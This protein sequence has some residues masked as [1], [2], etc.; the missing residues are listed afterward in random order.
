MSLDAF[1]AARKV[2]GALDLRHHIVHLELIDPADIPRFKEL[3]VVANFQGLWAYPDEYITKLTEPIL[4][5]ER[6]GRLYPIGSV[7]RSGA[8][9]AGGSDWSVSSLNPLEAIQVAV[10]RRSIDGGEGPAWL[11]NELID[12]RTALEAYTVNGAYLSHRET[13]TG[14]IE[15]EKSADI[16]V[17]DRDLFAI[18]PSE[19]HT[20]RVLLTLLEGDVVYRDPALAV[21]W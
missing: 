21:N 16:V 3:G 12:L 15:P 20:A 4:G 18:P 7:V 6:S 5:P 17:L 14:S 1:A 19:I 11:P 13:M 8:R 2:N 9:I 10:T